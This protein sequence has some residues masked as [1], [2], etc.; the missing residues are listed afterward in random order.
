MLRGF[1]GKLNTLPSLVA[2]AAPPAEG[3]QVQRGDFLCAR[4]PPRVTYVRSTGISTHPHAHFLGEFFQEDNKYRSRKS[5]FRTKF[6]FGQLTKFP[7]L[8][9]ERNKRRRG[10]FVGWSTSSA[11]MHIHPSIDT[12]RSAEEK[13]QILINAC[14]LGFLLLC[15]I[16]QMTAN[17]LHIS[18]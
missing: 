16:L 17:L 14:G 15:K 13:S 3:G 1:L 9:L 18:P 10:N 11:S 5:I 4:H 6:Q 8:D 7:L 12:S 2:Q